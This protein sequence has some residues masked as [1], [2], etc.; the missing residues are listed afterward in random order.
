[1]RDG[2]VDK[3]TWV[4]VGSSF[5]PTEMQAA[6]LLAQLEAVADNLVERQAIWAAYETGLAPLV[7]A[8]HLAV[9]RVDPGRTI[10]YH[11]VFIILNSPAEREM[12][13]ASLAEAGIHT[14]THYEPLHASHMGSRL[15]SKP[16]DLPVTLDLAARLLRLPMHNNLSINDVQS[17][18]A[19]LADCF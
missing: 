9:G 10:N 5:Y 11:A 8:G 7:A 18:C 13:C 4:D 2:V 17:I 15:G 12:V 3:Y 1:M 19:N 16:E 14:V 6:F